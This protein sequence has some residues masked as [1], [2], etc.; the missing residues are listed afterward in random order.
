[1]GRGRQQ[2]Y[3][4]GRFCHF[5]IRE[6]FSEHPIFQTKSIKTKPKEEWFGATGVFLGGIYA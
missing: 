2:R 6:A 3:C 4:T 5:S 1:M